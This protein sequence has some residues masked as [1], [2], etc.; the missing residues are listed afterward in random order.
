MGYIIE[1][2]Y[3]ERIEIEK[4]KRNFMKF[5]SFS[6]VRKDIPECELCDAMFDK[7]DDTNLAF[8][9]STSNKLICDVCAILVIEGG[10]KEINW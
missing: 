9:K 3:T 2:H 7:E 10:A 6:N 4:V 1:Q 8:V 5:Q